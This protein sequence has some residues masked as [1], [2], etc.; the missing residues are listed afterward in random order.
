MLAHNREKIGTSVPKAITSILDAVMRYRV[1]WDDVDVVIATLL[2]FDPIGDASNKVYTLIKYIAISYLLIKYIKTIRGIPVVVCLFLIYAVILSASTYLN[3]HSFTWMLSGTMS[4]LHIL[5]VYCVYLGYS[6]RSGGGSLIKW[7]ASILFCSLAITD[8]LIVLLPYDR[9]SSETVYLIGN[10]FIVSYAHCFASGLLFM[11]FE[12]DRRLLSRIPMVYSACIAML[13]TCTTGAILAVIMLAFTFLPKRYRRLVSNPV[14]LFLGIAA[15]NVLTWGVNI[16]QNPLFKDLLV[17]FF[18]KPPTL[19]GRQQL[20]SV[21]FDLVEKQPL[22]GYGYLTDIFRDT[23][24]YGNAQNGLFHIVTQAGILGAVVYFLNVFALLAKIGGARCYGLYLY[25]ITMVVGSSV[26]INLS[27]QFMYGVVAIAAYLG[28]ESDSGFAPA[29]R[30]AVSSSRDLFRRKDNGMLVGIMTMQRIPNYGSFMQAFALKRMIESLGHQ[31]VFVDYHVEPDVEH[32]NDK[33]ER[34]KCK[35]EEIKH[36]IKATTFGDWLLH[37]VKGQDKL[38][39]NDVMFSCDDLLG[40]TKQRKFLTKCD[41]LVIGSDEVFN[42]LQLGRNVGYSLELFGK[43][44]RARS[45]ISYA[46]SFGST[47][48]PRLCDYGVCEELGVLLDNFA[49]VSVR[50]KNSYEIV[51]AISRFSDPELHLDPVLVGG[52]EDLP[53]KECRRN[54]FAILYGYENRFT[55]S[56]CRAV[57]EIAHSQGLKVIALGEP[58]PICDEFVR[59]RPDELFGYFSR[60]A[61]VITDTFHGTIFS[62]LF[63]K[64]FLTIPRVSRNGRGGNEEKLCYLLETLGLQNRTLG[65]LDDMAELLERPI[66][67]SRVDELR[68]KARIRSLKYLSDN[69]AADL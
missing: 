14:F 63:H 16:F 11:L 1:K 64:P 51:S 23:V 52:V 46:A 59:C 30:Y 36:R 66:D 68:G 15:V 27:L 55:E 24:G 39:R 43:N 17:N 3:T 45:V 29:S 53:W 56:E 61:W 35:L 37:A 69:I 21:T 65:S 58:Q 32:R 48:Y 13:V 8:V 10:K 26:E 31:V 41:V 47:T 19:S 25:L 34:R 49:A 60:T 18:G 67:Y 38:A 12:R 44:A 57:C 54:N 33:T 4:V 62:V 22:L 40:I 28:S 6:N 42:C 5:A 2:F 20:Y 7:L 50:D 9:T